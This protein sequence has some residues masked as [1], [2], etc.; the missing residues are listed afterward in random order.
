MGV[1]YLHEEVKRAKSM[2]EDAE[3]RPDILDRVI[4]EEVE[5]DK[6]LIENLSKLLGG[7]VEGLI[8]KLRER[9]GE[10]WAVRFD[11]RELEELESKERDL[12]GSISDR[13]ARLEE[14]EKKL[15]ES[16]VEVERLRRVREIL[17]KA[18][19]FYDLMDMVRDELFYRDRRVLRSLNSE[20]TIKLP[21]RRKL[22][23]QALLR[24][25]CGRLRMSGKGFIMDGLGVVP[26]FKP[27]KHRPPEISSLYLMRSAVIGVGD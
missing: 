5:P 26:E 25:A 1:S 10:L 14:L 23:L 7:E 2:F 18:K 11:P 4:R 12:I 13:R 24:N 8:S 3:Q 15:K 27:C 20:G 17:V 19:E 9:M 21:A 6:S 16:S 22:S